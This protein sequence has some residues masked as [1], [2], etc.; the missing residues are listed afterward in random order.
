MG[1]RYNDNPPK[2]ED[3]LIRF[4]VRNGAT[5]KI[6]FGCYYLRGHDSKLHDFVGWPNP[7]NRDAICQELSNFK[8]FKS[9]N[10]TVELE[11]IHLL[12]EGY[13]EAAVAYES[14][15][16]AQYLITEA[17]IDEDDDNI[18]RV[19]ITANLPEFSDKPIDVRFTV[20]VRKSSETKIDSVCHGVI[21]ILPG[22]VYPGSP[23]PES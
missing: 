20:F 2:P 13:D 3:N 23:Y 14:S 21:T 18:V 8:L 6:A 7:S 15:E 11:E 4:A 17:N 5:A 16:H 22:A 9:K 12:E 1:Y 10:K 19:R